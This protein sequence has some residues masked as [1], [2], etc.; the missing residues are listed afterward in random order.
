MAE[1]NRATVHVEFRAIE[2]QLPVTGQNL[3]GEGF[4]EFNQVEISHPQLM[5]L[6]HLAQRWN[7][8]NAHDAR[9]YADRS[10]SQNAGERLEIIFLGEVLAGENYRGGAIR[11]TRRI[12]SRDRSAF[13]EHRRELSHLLHRGSQEQMFVTSESLRTFLTFK[14][15]RGEFAIKSVAVECCRRASLRAESICIL[16]FTS[17]L[18]LLGQNFGGFAHQ[19]FRQGTEKSIA[20]H[21]IDEFLIPQAIAPPRAVKI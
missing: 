17:D 11:N 15:D 10:H 12:A 13:R 8:R 2:M 16:L 20:I 14:R 21:A 18:V 1:R 9:I 5:L 7:W 19:H 4:V 6:L 3:G